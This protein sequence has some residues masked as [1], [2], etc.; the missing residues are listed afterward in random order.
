MK[1][2]RL[3][4][5]HAFF[6]LLIM[7]LLVGFGAGA[8]AAFA[9]EPLVFA[10]HVASETEETQALELIPDTE[11]TTE[12]LAEKPDEDER[13][14]AQQDSI[15]D[16]VQSPANAFEAEHANSTVD[17]FEAEHANSTVD[18][19]TPVDALEAEHANSTVDAQNLA[20][21]A[22]EPVLVPAATSGITMW[23]LYNPN[24]G[25]HFYTGNLYE[26]KQVAK[27]GW[28]WE[29]VGWVAP[30][31]GEPVYRLYNPNAGDHQYTLHAAERDMLV[32]VGWNYEGIGWYSDTNKTVALLRQY[33]P[34]ARAGSHNFTV[35]T[36]E[37]NM[38][39]QAGWKDEGIG[40]Y[41]V[42]L[43]PEG[44]IGSFWLDGPGGN[45]A[46]VKANGQ[47]QTGYFEQGAASYY[48]PSSNGW[49]VR[50]RYD[51]GAGHVYLADSQGRLATKTGWL[52]TS[53]YGDGVQRYWMERLASGAVA[54]RSGHFQVVGNHYWGLANKGYVLRG[55]LSMGAGVLLANNDGVL[56]WKTGWL[57]TGDYDG[58]TIQ[59]YYIDS[60]PGSGL[61]GAHTGFFTVSNKSY[62]GIKDKGYV[63]RNAKL[64]YGT[65]TFDA[66]NDGALTE[67]TI[68]APGAMG[69]KAQGYSSPTNY[70]ILVNVNEHLVNVYQGSKGAWNQVKSMLCTV[71][72]PSTPTVRGVFS[73]GSR[74]YSFGT[75]TYTCYYWVQW[76]GDYLFHTIKYVAGTWEVYDG[77]L[78]VDAS[79]GCVRLA[80]E[81]AKWIYQNIPSG[82]TVVVY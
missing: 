10:E 75:N 11:Q 14:I 31:S 63:L 41:G 71:G 52:I 50:G 23:R 43:A 28:N 49:V 72:K 61:H 5:I 18:V 34:N 62:Y 42:A 44:T 7:A 25:E 24:S 40:W 77:R 8:P 19:P 66:N 38:L 9:E 47:V 60:S 20:K 36:Q 30:S 56:A 55:K 68:Y 12:L 45:R 29:G 37:K 59:R 64:E 33:N 2:Y 80:A 6:V 79:D 82:T 35:N 57:V 32:T 53:A 16:D 4:T 21:T 67:R 81:N 3:H 26:A 76:N 58:G 54:A 15:E 13:A 46:W 27:A 22:E 65:K 48:A 74:G 69:A 17:V 70:L 51:D 1:S 78:G 39:V 73:V